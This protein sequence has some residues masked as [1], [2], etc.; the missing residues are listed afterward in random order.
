MLS[1]SWSLYHKAFAT[2][3]ERF[4]FRE[5]VETKT[6]VISTRN[7]DVRVASV[8]DNMGHHRSRRPTS[9]D[10]GY[11]TTSEGPNSPLKDGAKRRGGNESP[12]AIP[13]QNEPEPAVGDQTASL[14]SIATRTDLNPSIGTQLSNVQLSNFTPPQLDELA[15]LVSERGVV[16]LR[17]QDLTAEEQI[18]IFEHYGSAA[19]TQI[20]E[21]S[22]DALKIKSS[23]EDYGEKFLYAAE[24]R[25]EW[26]S[27]RS[28]EATPPSYSMLK[29][30]E[31][32]GE[33]AWVR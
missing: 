26:T 1:N 31:A 9:S 25:K 28:F 14:L 23:K 24:R 33:T 13:S 30:D 27:D 19:G 2:S 12:R 17:D 5:A 29:V 7:L 10:S 3:R 16:F 11:D 18:R 6:T 22:Q 4:I 32:G 8:D 15:S 20:V 21:K